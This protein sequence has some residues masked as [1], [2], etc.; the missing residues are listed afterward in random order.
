M[1]YG[2]SCLEETFFGARHA[3]CAIILLHGVK[4][5]SGLTASYLLLM[6]LVFIFEMERH[7]FREVRVSVE[8]LDPGSGTFM[9]PP[10]YGIG[11]PESFLRSTGN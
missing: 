11:F 7:H 8:D 3:S 5:I 1:P 6:V 4:N 2:D 10:G 9:T